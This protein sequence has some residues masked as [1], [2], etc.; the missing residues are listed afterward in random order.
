VITMNVRRRTLPLIR[1]LAQLGWQRDPDGWTI[2]CRDG[3]G[4][5]ARLRI[6]LTETG[7]VITPTGPGPWRLTPLQVGRLRA[8]LRDAVIS[9][10]ELSG[11]DDVAPPE[12]SAIPT[13]P[14]VPRRLVRLDPPCRPTTADITAREAVSTTQIREVNHASTNDHTSAIS[15]A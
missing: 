14:K 15:A 10:G 4:H 1:L 9:L 8:G 3:A 12:R 5:R 2:P 13:A 6:A 11:D 7:V